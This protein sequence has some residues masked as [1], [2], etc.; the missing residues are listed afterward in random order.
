MSLITRL[1][2]AQINTVVGDFKGNAEKIVSF[3]EKAK[4]MEAHIIAFP[5]L[6][7]CGYPPEDLLL[8]PK[9]IE[10]GMRTLET[11]M[12]SSNG[13]VSIIGFPHL[14]DDLY[15]AAAILFNEKLIASYHKIFLP[16]YGVFDE[17]RYF[18]SGAEIPVF[19]A[20]RL[21]FGVNVCEDIWFAEGPTMA[22]AL[23]P[24][25]Q[26]IINL[27][28]SPY[29]FNKGELREKMVGM[30]AYDNQVYV[31]YVNATGGQDELVFDGQSLVAAPDGR[32][33]ARGKQFEEELILVDL[34]LSLMSNKH[35]FDPKRRQRVDRQKSAF[36]HPKTVSY[37]IDDFKLKPVE[38]KV[39]KATN[40]IQ[41]ILEPVA[42]IYEALITGLGDYVKKNGFSKVVVGL[43]GGI[44]SALT[45][46]ICADALGKENVTG[47]TMP[48]RYSS[49]G[50][51]EDS[52]ELARNL[53]ISLLN[54]P[55][56][57]MF[58]ALKTSLDEIF[59]GLP[60]NITEENMQPRIRGTILMALSNKFNWLVIATGNKSELAVGYTTLYGD[61][62]GGFA[63]LKDI[64]KTTVYELAKYRNSLPGGPVIP[65]STIDK[66]PSAELKPD[67]RDEDSLP[68]Y[69][70]L[71]KIL[72]DHVEVEKSVGDLVAEGL[73]EDRI[74][75]TIRSVDRNEYKRRQGPIGIKIS[76]RAFGKD[77]RVPITNAYRE[78]DV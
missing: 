1:A 52:E 55:I 78:D 47:V 37:R 23:E 60:E 54:V 26:L 72:K 58:E 63:V 14:T 27:S 31:V 53:E 74:R 41:P 62:V 5:E 43:S 73:P 30:R 75:W 2:I 64:Y 56:E 70:M 18:K 24:G 15:N 8:K 9:F 51:V 77:R 40:V 21:T 39:G 6:A 4:S 44:D 20:D 67:Q 28:S 71:D 57:P 65:Q 12:P 49:K 38:N 13:I 68:P 11:I 59:T 33:I 45:A 66:A 32:I 35:L 19:N 25:C 42:E 36:D 16:N 7:L 61:M 34:D 17:F 69:P 3:I 10:D 50:S 46:T 22:Q 76:P 48:S 29:Y